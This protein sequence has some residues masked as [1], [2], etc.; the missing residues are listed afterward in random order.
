MYKSLESSFVTLKFEYSEIG[1]HS[2]FNT[3]YNYNYRNKYPRNNKQNKLCYVYWY[4][5][6]FSSRQILVHLT[7]F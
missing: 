5:D 2:S 7:F 4:P 6:T 1:E 3:H